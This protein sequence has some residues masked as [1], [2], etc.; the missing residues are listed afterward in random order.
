MMKSIQTYYYAKTRT[1]MFLDFKIC[2]FRRHQSPVVKK[3][4]KSPKRCEM[5][6][7]AIFSLQRLSRKTLLVLIQNARV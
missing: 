5:R 6:K 3:W 7:C 2:L 1:K 4:L